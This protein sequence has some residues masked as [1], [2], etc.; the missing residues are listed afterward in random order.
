MGVTVYV[1]GWHQQ[2][3][4]E[5]KVYQCDRYPNLTEADFA[6]S[7]YPVDD[8]GR[9][10][11]NERVY[12]EPFPC[13]EFGCIQWGAFSESLGLASSD[14]TGSLEAGALRAVLARALRL[15]NSSQRQAKASTPA[16]KSGNMITFGSTAE[17]VARR[18]EEFVRLLKFAIDR[19]RGIYWG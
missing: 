6:S 13:M 10:Y 8:D 16:T 7:G 9:H 11:V 3:Y 18:A 12:D 19:N 2:A 4:R 17:S 15:L 5:E 14:G 1:E